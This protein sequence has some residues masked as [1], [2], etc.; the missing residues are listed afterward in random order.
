MPTKNKAGIQKEDSYGGMITREQ[1]LFHEMRTTARLYCRGFS[2][3]EI[4]RII[5]EEN[6]F[7]YPSEKM[8]KNLAGVCLKR[9]DTLEDEGLI[10]A[11]ATE[12]A[13]CAK[14]ICLYAMMRQYP[15]VRD[16]MINIIGEKYR[17][18]NLSY[19]RADLNVFFYRLQEQDNRVAAW[20]DSTVQKIKQVLNKLLAD[21][22]YLE[23][24]RSTTLN[25]VWISPI[26]ETAIR[27]KGDTRAL[28][29]FNCFL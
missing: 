6:L 28:A 12:S 24:I 11:I 13:S 20:S 8:I 1:F 29:A 21:I 10:E 18:M 25:P 16:F 14:Q 9:L 2:R 15:I 3:E 26:L 4:I 27:A 5:T 22:N 19:S 17:T 7:Q 23:T